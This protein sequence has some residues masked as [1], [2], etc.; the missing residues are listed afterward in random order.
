M[1]VAA[2]VLA[3]FCCGV[4]AGARCAAQV[5]AGRSRTKPG[6]PR[7]VSLPPRALET[8]QFLARRGWLAGA[9]LS[10]PAGAMGPALLRLRA[11]QAAARMNASGAQS[12]NAATATW[13]PLGPMAVETPNFGLVSGRISSLALDPSDITGNHL[14]VGTT[15]GVWEAQNAAASTPSSI[16]FTPLTDA[17]DALGGAAGASI[18]IGALTVQ[19]GGTG[20]IL[21]GTGDPNDALDSYYG[22]GILRS[23]DGGNTW[24]LIQQTDDLEQLQGEQTYSFV[25]EGFAGFAWSTVDPQLVVA[26][27][28]QAYEGTLVSA[29]QSGISYE[30]L[31]YSTDA[32]ASWN[33]ATI[34]DGNGADVQGPSDPFVVPDGNAATAVVWNPVRQVFIA[35][36]RYHGYYQ[37]SD[38]VTW[39]RL[40]EQ[41][42]AGLTTTNCPTN[43]GVPG[44]IACPIFRGALAV[45][46][47]TGDT[48]AWTVDADNQ[49]QGLWQDQCGLSAGACSNQTVTFGRQWDTSALEADTPS[50][51]ATIPNGDYNLALAAVPSQQDTLLF[52]GGNDLW[53]CSLA[54]GCVWRNTTN[55][56]TCM[57]AQVGEFQHALT[58]NPSNPL[59]IFAGNDSGLWRS[60]DA[61]GE[62]GPVCDS[63]DASHFQNLN[64]SLGSLAEPESI[65]QVGQ[66]SYTM[67]AGLGVNGT[68]GVKSTSGP[69]ADWPQILSGLGGP[70]AIDPS[71]PL[72]WYVN[73]APGVSIHACS[74]SIGCNPADFGSSPVIDNADVD[75]DGSTM[76]TPAPFLV[77]PL[78]NAQLLIGTCRVWRGPATGAGWSDGNAVSPILDTGQSGGAC[79][80]DA[81]IRSMAALALSG[82][83]EVIY[84]GMY[85]AQDGGANIPGHVL[86]AIVDPSSTSMP[87]WQDLSFN[88]VTNSGQ[89]LNSESFD[90]SSIYI[91]PHDA[92]GNTV[93]VTVEGMANRI[94]NPQTVYRSTDGGAHWSAITSNLPVAPANSVTVDPQNANTVYVATDAGV[95]FTTEVANCAQ[96]SSN[97]WSAF[98]TGLP[99]APV[100]A[101]SA[102]PPSASQQVL[103]AATYGRGI[104]QTPLW[105]S[106]ANLASASVSPADLSFPNQSVGAVTGAQTVTLYNTGS[107]ALA[108][109]GIALSGDFSETDNCVNAAI[110]PGESCAIQVIFAPTAT[111]SRTGQMTI[112]ANVYGGQI[113]VNLSGTGTPAGEVTLS[114]G[115]LDFGQVPSGTTSAPL[116]VQAA[117]ATTTD[118]PILSVAVT[119]PFVLA[120]NSCGTSAL[121]AQAS[122]QIE[123]AFAPTQTGSASGTLTLTDEAGI[124]TVAL[125]GTGAA[126]PADNLSPTAL[127]FPDTIAGQ[128]SAAQTVQLTN[129]GDE[130]LTSIAA[131]VSAGF[132]IASNNC[133]TQLAAQ[134]SC[135]IAVAFDPTAAGAQTGTL[136]VSDAL[137][138]QTVALSGTGL[139]APVFSV[140][141]SSLSF[142]SEQPGVASAPQTL[143]VSNTG[144]APMDNVGFQIT[145]PGAGSF[146]I[147]ATTCGAVLDNGASCSAQVTF[148]PTMAG[149]IAA[150]LAVSS[151]TLGVTPA[152]VALTGTAQLASGLGVSPT[153]IS[154]SSVDP[155]QT[156]AAQTVTITNTTSVSI[157][158][159]LVAVA[160]PFVLTQNDCSGSLGAGASCTAEVAFQPASCALATGALTVSSPAVA[161][162][163]SVA[164]YGS[165]GI[166][167]TPASISFPTTGAG[168]VSSPTTV[169]ITNLNPTTALAGLALNVPAGFTLVASTC[170]ST[171]AAQ[172]S[173]TAGVEFAPTAAGQQSG[174]LTVTSST[175]EAPPVALSGMGFDFTAAAAG[176][177]SQTVAS[178][179]TA[180]YSL[181]L[182]T[183]DGSQGKFSFQC[184]SLPADA[185][186]AFNPG[187]ETVG[188]GAQGNVMVEIATGP[189]TTASA[190]PA[191]PWPAAPL[192][193]GLFLLP[194]ACRRRRAL[195]LVALLAVVTCAGLVGCTSS[196]G[197]TGSAPPGSQSGAS[198]PAGT[199][200]VQVTASSTGVQHSVTLTLTVD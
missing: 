39:T 74:Q 26:A 112:S 63:S 163:S 9:Q 42:G 121:T 195:F 154:F 90:I 122:C 179:Q 167:V 76:T 38:G 102:A 193:C 61:V 168:T 25:G 176:S 7:R 156:S 47:Q 20:V 149:G 21:A 101:L 144:G 62:T 107:L 77:D 28:S 46:P 105:T 48:F 170:G 5:V 86:R 11:E 185:Q 60:T 94:A 80:G 194:L 111:G 188:A 4:F 68:A 189:A 184:S 87:V 131:S 116:P 14:Y 198:T 153:E 192:L 83:S 52:A 197:G 36:V 27:V 150:T 98:G 141:P 12:G 152:S 183:L 53:K 115:T 191:T 57:S 166:Q 18:S 3:A 34:T 169:T 134:A 140:S 200:T 196:G 95:Y 31:Y 30:G 50:G 173:C 103:V 45:N 132:Q 128:L 114:P 24:T 29:N 133:T 33:L 177:T 126:P 110:A 199:Y 2:W 91:D 100:V 22:G 32:G 55:S 65:S 190:A 106:G 164:L 54:M 148:D 175:V 145:G 104:W 43:P 81:L 97:C 93:Y 59:E 85:G 171:L 51:A 160:A 127:T 161:T 40:A 17:V 1:A 58:W 75:G 73:N 129:S 79:S 8:E 119:P 136:T 13:Q 19:P 147:A 88:P 71:D 89:A 157:S 49:D 125:S 186:C 137:R 15:G 10:A 67:M 44:S 84:V 35:A 37:S 180:S 16:T 162:A 178:G 99:P 56:T 120:S 118:I 143:T 23:T 182:S 135:S 108:P 72:N 130:P 92:T 172:A 146:A 187:T 109:T 124:Q 70:V 174:S 6:A 66:S 82:G 64:G 123:I 113:A 96:P 158:S 181:V 142:A 78:D 69:T 117:N 151:S 165:C 139:A 138:T 41:P 159:L 155:G